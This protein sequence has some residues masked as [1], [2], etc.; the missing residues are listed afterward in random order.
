METLEKP[1]ATNNRNFLS[2]REDG[3]YVFHHPPKFLWGKYENP[4]H[5][6]G[7]YHAYL[8]VPFC[9][10]ICT[11]CTFERKVFNKAEIE[12]Y[13]RSLL[14][15]LEL[16]RR[17]DDFSHAKMESVYLGGGTASLLSNQQIGASS[18]AWRRIS[19]SGPAW[20]VRS[21]AS[22]APSRRAIS[23]KSKTAA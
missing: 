3:A 8:H 19:V 9:R 10:S 11:F 20:S 14:D 18:T 6:W 21:S 16:R 5:Q 7:S 13:F 4:A 2:P 15:E 22:R 1:T 23:S 12:R 17:V